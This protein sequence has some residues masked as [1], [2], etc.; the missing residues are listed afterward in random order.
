L[1][2]FPDVNFSIGNTTFTLSVLQYLIISNDDDN[3]VCYTVFQGVNLHDNT[4]NLMWILGDYFLSRFYSVYDMKMNQVGLAKSISYDYLQTYPKSL[5]GNL[6][7]QTNLFSSS[8]SNYIFILLL[9]VL[10]IVFK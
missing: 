7:N 2:S 10:E 9:L 4:G 5:F 6:S 3:H 1:T 8:A